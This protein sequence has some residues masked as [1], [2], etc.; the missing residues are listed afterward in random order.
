MTQLIMRMDEIKKRLQAGNY[1]ITYH[2]HK[3]MVRRS[4]SKEEL[5]KLIKNGD[6]I[7]DYPDR[8]PCPVALILGHVSG[9]PCHVAMAC[10]EDRL[11]VVTVYWPDEELW[12]DDYARRLK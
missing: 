4:I 1:K 9:R 6:I 10:C 11:Y 8:C 2:A 5:V 12:D 3:R 7:E